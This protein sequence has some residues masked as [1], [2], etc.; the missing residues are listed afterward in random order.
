MGLV[1]PECP[2]YLDAVRDAVQIEQI[3]APFSLRAARAH[4]V[5]FDA[6]A[7]QLTEWT[8][9]Q[10][11]QMHQLAARRL[12]IK[13]M[14]DISGKAPAEIEKALL[15]L[16]Y[17]TMKPARWT[18]DQEQALATSFKQGGPDFC[19]QQ[20]SHQRGR[21]EINARLICMGLRPRRP[22][23]WH[24][25]QTN[26]LVFSVLRHRHID[27]IAYSLSRSRADV[28]KKALDLGCA[29]THVLVCLR[30]LSR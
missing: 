15:F 10:L 19:A 12:S 9:P 17:S 4:L 24:V 11:Q 14:R 21:S 29:R 25:W 7:T 18:A 23:T 1:R 13:Q 5:R 20:F 16:G 22:R 3:P 28:F 8:E 26:Y 2:E 30:P 6:A 27:E